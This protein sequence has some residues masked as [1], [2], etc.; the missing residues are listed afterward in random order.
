MVAQPSAC[1]STMALCFCGGLCFL[2]KHSHL[3]SS[4]LPT[5]QAASSQPTAVSP[6]VC[7]PNPTF[8]PPA[9]MCTGGHMSQAVAC[10]AVAQTICVGL[11]LSCLPQ[12]GCCTLL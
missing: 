5:S 12:T 11:S 4:S 3:H 9:P 1:H 7:S 6:W 10:R 8:Q 2:H